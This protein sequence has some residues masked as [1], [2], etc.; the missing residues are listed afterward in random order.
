MSHLTPAV[1]YPLDG[2]GESRGDGGV[3]G[4]VAVAVEAPDVELLVQVQLGQRALGTRLTT[5]RDRQPPWVTRTH[6]RTLINEGQK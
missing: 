4:D 2:A 5:I 3:P 1:T 6:T